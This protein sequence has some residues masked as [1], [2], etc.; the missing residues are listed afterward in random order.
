MIS[1]IVP[2]HNEERELGQSLTSLHAAARELA[3]HYELLVVD[4]ASGDRTP[5]IAVEHG[6]RVVAVECRHIAATRNAGARQSNGNLLVFVDADTHVHA[7][8]LGAAI[9]AVDAGAIGGGAGVRLRG[10]RSLPQRAAMLLLGWMF[11]ATGIAPG[12]F[13]FCTRGAFTATGGFDERYFA[14]EDVAFSRALARHG[15]F[16]ILRAQALTSAR[17]LRTFSIAEHLRLVL[18]FG[19]RGR[20]VLRSREHLQLWYAERRDDSSGA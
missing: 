12:C 13:I 10:C 9:A 1:F 17:K 3:L 15:H 5:A 11:R 6:A 14:G 16:V 7:D 8:L 4:D 19:L 20:A 18:R 2:A